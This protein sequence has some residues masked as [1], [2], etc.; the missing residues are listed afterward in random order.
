MEIYEYLQS[1]GGLFA[2]SGVLLLNFSALTMYRADLWRSEKAFGMEVPN[3]GLQKSMLS[4]WKNRDLIDLKVKHRLYFQWTLAATLIVFAL[5]S[6]LLGVFLQQEHSKSPGV[7]PSKQ[8]IGAQMIS[9]QP[10][11][12]FVLRSKGLGLD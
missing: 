7:T 9:I 11:I 1:L 3:V 8:E 4:F 12:Y 10:Q 5:I 2:L 6:F